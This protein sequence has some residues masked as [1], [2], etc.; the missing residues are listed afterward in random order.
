MR[1][2]ICGAKLDAQDGGDE[3]SKRLPFCSERCQRID[4]G[5]WLGGEYR[6]A[7]PPVDLSQVGPTADQPIVG[8]GGEEEPPWN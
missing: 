5:R 8:Q 2:P 3:A 4:L 6:I 7:G 1:C